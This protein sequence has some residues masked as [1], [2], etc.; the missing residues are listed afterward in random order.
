MKIFSGPQFCAMY[1]KKGSCLN[2]GAKGHF[3][4]KTVRI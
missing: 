4:E 1:P 3:I 2:C